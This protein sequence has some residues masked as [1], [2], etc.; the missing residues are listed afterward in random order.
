MRH[1]KSDWHSSAPTDYARPLN[2]RGRGDALR[3]GQWL[4]QHHI[5]PDTILSSSATRARQTT[6]AVIQEL[7][8]DESVVQYIDE[9][10]LANRD[11][12]RSF[13]ERGLASNQSILLVAHN[14]GMDDLVE[15]LA[16]APPA[17]SASGKLVTTGAIAR[18][19]LADYPG[20]LG[21]GMATSL[22]IIR[23]RE[24]T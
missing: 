3:M 7:G 11:T 22:Q 18:I 14:P 9:L 13:L 16:S 19:E 10:Y 2:K 23:P 8:L 21:Q 5:F 20:R 4:R 6:M 15:W 17:L 24:L 1:A 12:L